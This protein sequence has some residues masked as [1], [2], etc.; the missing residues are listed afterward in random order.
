MACRILIVLIVLFS[1]TLFADDTFDRGTE[2]AKMLAL[3]ERATQYETIELDPLEL[4]KAPLQNQKFLN[5]FME[6][7]LPF[8]QEM[9]V[10]SH[11]H[12]IYDIALDRALY[13]DDAEKE[14]WTNRKLEISK[15]ITEI[16][17]GE[18]YA[19]A[20][21]KFAE[22]AEGLDGQFPE[23][24]RKA[25]A[26]AEIESFGPEKIETLNRL[27]EL[28]QKIT[29]LNNNS[30]HAAGL[31]EAQVR[32]LEIQTSFVEGRIT[33]QEATEQKRKLTSEV[34]Y[35]LH[36]QYV[37]RA[38][39][40]EFNEGAILRTELANSKGFKTWAEFA[41]RKQADAYD[42]QL[43]TV[44]AK[45]EWLWKIIEVTDRVYKLSIERVAK[46]N[47]LNPETMTGIEFSTLLPDTSFIKKYFPVGKVDETW[48]QTML[49]SGFSESVFEQIH[50]DGYPRKGKATHAYMYP[51][52]PREFRNTEID[53]ITL[54]F[55]HPSVS[56]PD[57]WH[58]AIIFIVQNFRS[59]G[60][61][62]YKTAFHEGGHA[63]DQ[64]HR[65]NLTT[66]NSPAYSYQEIASMLMEKIPVDRDFILRVARAEDGKAPSEEE[67]DRFLANARLRFIIGFR[68]QVLN[69]IYD[70]M[71]WNQVYTES[72]PEF[73]ETSK[74]ILNQLEERISK[75][76]IDPVEGVD[77]DYSNFSTGH[78][79]S[80]SMRY[81]GYI[82]AR[83]AVELSATELLD[84][85][86]NDSGRRSFDRQ[87]TIANHLIEGYYRRGHSYVFPQAVELFTG[88][89]FSVERALQPYL[90]ALAEDLG[91]KTVP[92]CAGPLIPRNN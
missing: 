89:K 43:K 92:K 2:R 42:D 77:L 14:E 47:G 90:K 88:E 1:S 76:A 68:Y 62:P 85:L 49:E 79:Y 8:W 54:D 61:T 24:A 23:M 78:F 83:I 7:M 41:A 34:G 58:P 27:S 31:S 82:G 63:L 37:A 33:L 40:E 56:D 5:Y 57:S 72:G 11:Q 80:G 32:S 15:Q 84:R 81:L 13:E 48:K 65:E 16:S 35:A 69:A 73:V 22:L 70:I 50:L 28:G 45:L 25:Q 17:N 18:Q 59:D 20:R 91:E 29:E 87:P 3:L 53:P 30:P 52:F 26:D 39:E 44:E 4:E 10:L 66:D 9:S 38:G 71:I 46:E 74:S 60:L 86:E 51:L 67:V 36:S 21:K 75:L 64:V 6:E 19:N 12:G 55:S